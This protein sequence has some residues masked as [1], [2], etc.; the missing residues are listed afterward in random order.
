MPNQEQT[1]KSPHGKILLSWNFPEFTQYERSKSWY[2]WI[3]LVMAGLLVYCFFTLNLLFAIIIIMSAVIMYLHSRRQPLDIRLEVT[4]DGLQIGEK[5]YDYKSLKNFWIIYEPPEVKNL[6]ISFK[7][8]V[9][10]DLRIPLE[11][12]NPLDVRKVLLDFLD[13][14][15]TKEEEPFADVLS[16]RLKL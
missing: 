2:F 6:Y 9:K 8:S 3:G 13:E 12:Q 7:S 11:K 5:F 1:K 16:R 14:D 4:E 15:L 10:P